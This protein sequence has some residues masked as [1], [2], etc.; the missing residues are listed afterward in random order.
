[1]SNA[2]C[3]LILVTNDD[4]IA[5]PGLRAAARAVRA[6]G[7]IIVAAPRW[8][9]TSAGRS[10]PASST[11]RIHEHALEIDGKQIGAY[12]VE[13]SPAQAVQ[14][15]ILELAPRMPDLVVAGINYG[16]NLGN[17]IT[18]SGTVGAVLEAASWGIIGLAASLGVHKQ[19]HQSHSME[20]SFDVASHFTAQLA[21]M[22]LTQK[23]P[24]D[25]DLIKI[26]VPAEATTAT[27]WRLTRVSRQSYFIPV[28]RREGPLSTASPLDYE[29]SLKLDQLE[30][31][32]DIYAFAF[33][34]V[35][36]V[37]P[38]SSDMTARVNLTDLEQALRGY[39]ETGTA[40]GRIIS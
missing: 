24:F 6:L 21:R 26:D 4:G 38:I 8:Q 30:P 25:V 12:A 10:K 20:V 16:E 33:D 7:E 3:P 37:S 2:C 9:Q 23:L 1:M 14:H 22:L 31:D 34:R 19:Y 11:G 36:S 5:S 32:S 39:A 40:R 13:G 17:G 15:A 27:P 18:V 35:V 29:A 28:L